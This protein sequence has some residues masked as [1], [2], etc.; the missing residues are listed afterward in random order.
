MWIKVKPKPSI[1]SNEDIPGYGTKYFVKGQTPVDLRIPPGGQPVE[2][3]EILGKYLLGIFPSQLE[4]VT[5][6]EE[7]VEEIE[8]EAPVETPVVKADAL[9]CPKCK[10]GPFKSLSGLH[11]HSRVHKGK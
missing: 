11:A 1:L 8:G 9:T 10:A 3:D 6:A 5:P 4:D 7:V 2:F